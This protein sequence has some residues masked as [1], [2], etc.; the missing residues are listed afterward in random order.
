MFMICGPFVGDHPRSRGG[1]RWPSARSAVAAGPSP[2]AR[3]RHGSV[4][5]VALGLGTIPARAGETRP[6]GSRLRRIW[7]HPRSR[8]GDC[9]CSVIAGKHR[10]P[11]PL[12][13]GRPARGERASCPWGTIPARAGETR[14]PPGRYRL[15]RDHPRS[16]GGDPS[17]SQVSPSVRGPSPLARGRLPMSNG[18]SPVTGTIPARA[19]E[20]KF[21]A[22]FGLTPRDHPR[23]RGGDRCTRFSSVVATGPSP[24]ARG[25]PFSASCP[26]LQVGTIPARAGETLQARC[27][28]LEYR[29]HP[30][31]RGGDA[32]CCSPDFL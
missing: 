12:A 26:R 22:A 17:S 32:H 9:S 24:L 10:G 19:G 14:R 25:R 18:R 23:S 4:V 8:G 28:V 1:D 13:R 3:G 20:T 16:R 15:R 29:D 21:N 27:S 5:S 11:S 2:L 31:S 30:R 6:N 7:D